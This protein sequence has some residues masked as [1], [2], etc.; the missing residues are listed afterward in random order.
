[1]KI[2]PEPIEFGKWDKWRLAAQCTNVVDVPVSGKLSVLG[3]TGINIATMEAQETGIIN[4][5]ETK[6]V[7]FDITSPA[8]EF[9]AVGTFMLEVN[10]QKKSFDRKLNFSAC[11]NDG[12]TPVMDGVISPGEWDNCHVITEDGSRFS[13]WNGVSDLSFKVYR[14][15]DY[16]NLYMA[17]DVT[18]DVF[19]QP[20]TGTDVWQGDNVQIALDPARKDGVGISNADY[21]ELGLSR[22]DKNELMTYVW[23]ADLV[24]KK[25][26]PI[27]AYTGAV[28]RT[29]DGHTIY[30]IA[31][32]WGFLIETGI[33]NENDCIGFSIAVNDND[34]NGRKGYLMYMRGI[35]DKKDA[36]SFEDMVLV[37]KK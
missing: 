24:V 25:D 33:V 20:Y 31:I 8:T 22:N 10:G 29:D 32:P 5:G 28:N 12:I 15:W 2:T 17:I 7:Y 14:K 13:K 16:D 1:M 34:G 26:R 23:L 36:N 11:V 19:C 35:A 9:G 27:A 37:K 3:A 21:F 18:D 4:P 6:M 30:E